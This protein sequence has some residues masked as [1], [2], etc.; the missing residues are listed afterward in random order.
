MLMQQQRSSVVTSEDF[1]T[2]DFGF[3]DNIKL[4]EMLIDSY[5]NQARAVLREYACNAWDEHVACGKA[6]VPIK[7]TL[8]TRSDPRLSVR[9]FGRGLPR[10]FMLDGFTKIGRSTKDGSAEDN[11][12]AAE[13]TGGFGIGRMVGF[14][15]AEQ[16]HVTS[17]HQNKKS[18]YVLTWDRVSAP[19]IIPLGP[20]VA[21]DLP[22]GLEV[23]VP[24]EEKMIDRY[25]REA[26]A[27]FEFFPTA[28]DINTELSGTPEYKFEGD[29]WHYVGGG[30]WG[31]SLRAIMG[32]VAYPVD[33]SEFRDHVTQEEYNFIARC[34]V[35]FDVPLGSLDLLISRESIRY[36]KRSIKTLLTALRT[37]RKE[38]SESLSASVKDPS[39]TPYERNVAFARATQSGPPSLFQ[40]SG[41]PGENK[42]NIGPYTVYL[43]RTFF[44][45]EHK[46][47]I[48]HASQHQLAQ[49][50]RPRL[51]NA[52]KTLRLSHDDTEIFVHDDL[53]RNSRQPSRIWANFKNTDNSVF[54]F[55]CTS[56]TFDAIMKKI[57]NPDSS[58]IRYMS[59]LEPPATSTAY[60][61]KSKSILKFRKLQ[62]FESS[63]QNKKDV[64]RQSKVPE[65]IILDTHAFYI[66]TMNGGPV[67]TFTP[68]QMNLYTSA[69]SKQLGDVPIY[70][71]P[72]TLLHKVP[73]TWEPWH[74]AVSE[75]AEKAAA[76]ID[77]NHLA[78]QYAANYL[79]HD[80]RKFAEANKEE[81]E[82]YIKGRSKGHFR[83]LLE[84]VL[85]IQPVGN[86]TTTILHSSRKEAFEKARDKAVA[87]NDERLSK[88]REQN[89][90]LHYLTTDHPYRLGRESI[91]SEIWKL[92]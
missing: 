38:F 24:V 56:E 28:P 19:K 44:D 13:Q 57:G 62:W 45:L 87:E 26:S 86:Q 3:D 83:N 88:L 39:L 63:V 7:V 22:N 53:P 75:I 84:Q 66:V 79:P 14:G 30:S 55:E 76:S 58:R 1:D 78:A 6:D 10:D 47:Y 35:D 8:P 50:E 73:D 64:E 60:R 46:V 17:V 18:T 92:A 15:A 42:A 91:A 52:E 71:V 27:V 40:L 48:R 33:L 65:G 59:D 72:K 67:E 54:M 36:R 37:F 25:T 74:E 61:S 51:G 11:A 85:D 32:V 12:S 29:S 31:G 82:K 69:T 89:P 80:F 81:A 23:I 90:L 41:T 77:I 43:K 4:L 34:K 5:S 2:A 16:F 68:T 49:Y 20:E 21:T 9:D 70:F